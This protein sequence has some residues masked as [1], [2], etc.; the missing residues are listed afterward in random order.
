MQEIQRRRWREREV[1][2]GVLAGKL[3]RL[4]SA[5]SGRG[6]WRVE[7][8]R[9]GAGV[10]GEG[11]RVALCSTPG[12]IPIWRNSGN[13]RDRW[14]LQNNL[15]RIQGKRKKEGA[16]LRLGS[17]GGPWQRCVRAQLHSLALKNPQIGVQFVK[18][19]TLVRKCFA[20]VELC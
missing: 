19:T 2:C 8:G 13:V 6:G 18:I 14:V 15:T 4:F 1:Q 20:A 10:R 3:L 5:E 11:Q 16:L 9:E 7:Q 17:A 12:L